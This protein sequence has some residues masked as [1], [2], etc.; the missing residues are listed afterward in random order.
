MKDLVQ[1]TVKEWGRVDVVVNNAGIYWKK[2]LTKTSEKDWDLMLGV[3]LKGPF[4]LCKH[5]IPHMKKGASIINVSSVLGKVGMP[6]AT[7][8]CAAKGGLI[9][10]TKALALE[11]ANKNVRVNAIAPGPIATPM[12]LELSRKE[13]QEYKE[14]VPLKRSGK[15]E[16]VANAI[17]FLASNQASYITGETLFVD[18][19]RASQ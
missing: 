19:G 13:Q 9:T 6:G 12:L 17:L 14:S 7:A 2:A 10:F 8:Y 11:L 3:N 16:E 15:P 18:G 1:K 5:A 4:L